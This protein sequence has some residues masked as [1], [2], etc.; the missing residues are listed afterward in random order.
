MAS[1]VSMVGN[2]YVELAFQYGKLTNQIDQKNYPQCPI[3]L[4]IDK[5]EVDLES[6]VSKYKKIT[7]YLED[8]KKLNQARYT[9]GAEAFKITNPEV[10]QVYLEQVKKLDEYATSVGARLGALDTH[11]TNHLKLNAITQEVS[12]LEKRIKAYKEKVIDGTDE[13]DSQAKRAELTQEIEEIRAHVLNDYRMIRKGLPDAIPNPEY[14]AL[15]DEGFQKVIDKINALRPILNFDKNK[16][17]KQIQNDIKELKYYIDQLIPEE[18]TYE[19]VSLKEEIERVLKS[20][21]KLHPS[22][23]KYAPEIDQNKS[24]I[25]WMPLVDNPMR[26]KEVMRSVLKDHPEYVPPLPTGIAKCGIQVMPHSPRV[27]GSPRD[28][29]G[30]KPKQPVVVGLTPPVP[31]PRGVK[32]AAKILQRSLG[33]P[34]L[35]L[36]K[37]KGW[38]PPEKRK[39]E[40]AGPTTLEVPM[41]NSLVLQAVEPV[42]KATPELF[43]ALSTTIMPSHDSEVPA[44][45][46]SPLQLSP[47]ELLQE[48]QNSSVTTLEAFK[49]KIEAL[50]NNGR[51]TNKEE[52]ARKWIENAECNGLNFHANSVYFAVWKIAHDADPT[53]DGWNW[54]GANAPKDLGRLLLAIEQSRTVA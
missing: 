27:P 54:G 30:L 7:Q 12:D 13:G 38:S 22:I 53:A 19:R 46:S 18:D 45:P 23:F 35:N 31:S 37:V 4:Q 8:S 21:I 39:N 5:G 16:L 10:Q 29:K 26:L 6:F 1:A 34:S 24:P 28:L 50:Q 9:H 25:N 47:E 20:L 42:T 51:I 32:N 17:L 49:S 15:H 3:G 43:T 41:L 44:P 2:L 14:C 40:E 33:V 48:I 36:S 11:I 52:F